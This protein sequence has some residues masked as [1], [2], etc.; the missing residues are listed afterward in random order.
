MW[1]L[2]RYR[3]SPF[4]GTLTACGGSAVA[5]RLDRGQVPCHRMSPLVSHVGDTIHRVRSLVIDPISY[6]NP[7][8]RIA[9][10][11]PDSTSVEKGSEPWNRFGFAGDLFRSG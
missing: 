5:A 7:F 10:P 6:T 2:P 9:A 11:G 1:A 4:K 3:G 8:M